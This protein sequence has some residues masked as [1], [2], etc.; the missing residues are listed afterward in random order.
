MHGGVIDKDSAYLHHFFQMARNRGFA[1]AQ[2]VSCVPTGAHQHRFRGHILNPA[3]F[4]PERLVR[5]NRIWHDVEQ[6]ASLIAEINL[7]AVS[8]MHVNQ[9]SVT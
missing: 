1:K 2:W 5:Q 4:R 3:I 6:L 8:Y 7:C 9:L